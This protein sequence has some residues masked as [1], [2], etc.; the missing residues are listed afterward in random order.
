MQSLEIVRHPGAVAV[1]PMTADRR[2]LLVRQRRHAVGAE[3]LE[4]PAG[5][6]DRPGEELAACA[7]RELE[8]ET[9]YCCARLTPLVTLLS[10]PGFSDERIH[11]FLATGLEPASG[12]PVIDEEEETSPEWIGLDEA[13][14]AI[15]T[16]DIVDA[17][18]IVGLLLARLALDHGEAGG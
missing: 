11:L 17:K 4:I 12:P 9:G 7:R 1:V 10:S 13:V 2:V 6:L 5:K 18:T 15:R 14:G 8:E 3:L 16:G